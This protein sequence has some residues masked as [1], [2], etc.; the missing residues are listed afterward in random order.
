[1]GN[2]GGFL[3]GIPDE[4]VEEPRP[5]TEFVSYPQQ[6]LEVEVPARRVAP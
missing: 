3:I 4:G 2:D 6:R 1:M 5:V